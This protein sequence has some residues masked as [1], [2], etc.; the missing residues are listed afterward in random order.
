MLRLLKAVF[1]AI[2]CAGLTFSLNACSFSASSE[3]LSKSV[4]SS[5]SSLTSFASKAGEHYENDVE[6]YTYA[7]LK[8]TSSAAVD[9]DS[10]LK[11]LSDVA[12]EHGIADWESDTHTYAGI[13]KA[14]KKAG[15]QG[16]AYETYKKNFAGSDAAK[17]D[18]IQKGYESGE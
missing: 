14:L 15:I 11:G 13:G 18:D 6:D 12:A 17:M 5:S 3:S 7:Y 9:Y 4:S 1:I 10:F 16:V 8:S 2:G